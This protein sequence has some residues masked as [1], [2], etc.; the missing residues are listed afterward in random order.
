MS[1]TSSKATLV[2]DKNYTGGH[3]YRLRCLPYFILIG[4]AKSGTSDFTLRISKHPVF[5]K[6]ANKELYWWNQYRFLINSTLSDYTDL[7]DQSVRY[8]ILHPSNDRFYLRPYFS[9]VTGEMT[10]I[11]MTDVAYWR[12]DPRYQMIYIL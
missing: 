12:E 5:F 1:I 6:A 4:V 11:T 7:F 8:L 3:R 10:G 9:G 2:M